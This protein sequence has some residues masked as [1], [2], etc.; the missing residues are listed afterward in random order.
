MN[1]TLLALPAELH[2]K[3]MSFLT[4]ADL[5]R[6][7]LVNRHF[8]VTLP[9]AR[10]RREGVCIQWNAREEDD[11]DE[12]GG[13]DTEEYADEDNDEETDEDD[14]RSPLMCSMTCI[15]GLKDGLAMDKKCRNYLF[16]ARHTEACKYTF[17]PISREN[18]MTEFSHYV[19]EL[20]P[21]PGKLQMEGE[22]FMV[23]A[24]AFKY[25]LQG[26]I[27]RHYDS[28]IIKKIDDAYE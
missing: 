20:N 28:G 16:H 14:G 4:C 19:A 6:L 17:H 1:P 5:H 22:E 2:F 13:E 9:I 25:E 3:V 15:R 24:S 27:H 21:A 8:A 12:D 18:L 26:Q 10:L 11:V 7:R 23:T